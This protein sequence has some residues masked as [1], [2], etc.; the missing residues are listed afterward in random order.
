MRII[1]IHSQKGGVGKSTTAVCLATAATLDGI[2][3]CVLDLDPQSTATKWRDRRQAEEPAVV[4]ATAGRLEKI[5]EIPRKGGAQLVIIDTAPKNESDARRAMQLSDIVIIPTTDN[6]GD[7]EAL[8]PSVETAQAAKKPAYI[9]FCR[10]ITRSAMLEQ[11]RTAANGY[12]AQLIPITSYQRTGY[13]RAAISG[14]TPQETEPGGRAAEDI[15]S[16]Y[17]WLKSVITL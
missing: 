10:V 9:L 15:T 4:P 5:L 17:A 2:S 8:Q 11:A 7:L 3:A 14:Q 13:A 1:T 16:L 12:E 6:I